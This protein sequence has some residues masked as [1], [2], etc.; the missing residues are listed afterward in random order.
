M[1]S[2][3]NNTIIIDLVMI[4]ILS[5]VYIYLNYS[6]TNNNNTNVILLVGW[7]AL[8][9]LRH[10]QHA[11]QHYQCL[12]SWSLT[13]SPESLTFGASSTVLEDKSEG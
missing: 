10:I 6:I 11:Q 12:S 4:L 2:Y 7:E 1:Q 5:F 8:H 3:T 13:S 9:L